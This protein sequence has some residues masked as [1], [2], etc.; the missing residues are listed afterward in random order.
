MSR[1]GDALLKAHEAFSR[2]DLLACE[3][4]CRAIL[5]SEPEQAE[6]LLL[7][8]ASLGRQGRAAEALGP[9]ERASQL[10]PENADAHYSLGMALTE[11]R[12]W[13]EAESAFLR[14]LQHAPQHAYAYNNLGVALRQVGG[15]A[16]AIACFREALAID[17]S[18]RDAQANLARSLLEAERYKE[19]LPHFEAL[20]ELGK[21]Q[22]AFALL[23]AEVLRK[24]GRCRAAVQMLREV[25]RQVPGQVNVIWQL[26]QAERDAGLFEDAV[27]TWAGVPIS[28]PERSRFE[29]AAGAAL[30]EL[31]RFA[32]SAAAYRRALAKDP[33]NVGA[34]LGLTSIKSF[35]PEERDI[36]AIDRVAQS[37]NLKK[38]D[39]AQILFALAGALE[40]KED[41]DRAFPNFQ[42]ANG[43]MRQLKGSELH[44]VIAR[45]DALR[46]R[47]QTIAAP[48]NAY[49]HPAGTPRP[50]FIVG[51]PRS[52]TT[53]VE[54]ILA[55]HPE[56]RGTGELT[57][58]YCAILAGVPLYP[59]GLEHLDGKGLK[60][61]SKHYLMGLADLAEGARYATDKLPVNYE[62]V[63]LIAEAFPEA[64]I[65]H[66]RREPLDV[67][68]S[69]YTTIFFEGQSFSYDLEELGRYYRLYRDMMTHWK[70]VVP[71]DRLIELVYEDLVADPE[72]QIRRLLEHCGLPWSDACLRFHENERPVQ[73]ASAT[74]VRQ[75]L[76]SSSVGR[77]RRYEK[78]LQP[79][80]DLLSAP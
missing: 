72:P 16:L 61:I 48:T 74:Q 6:A 15:L 34:W 14:A 8:G 53:L 5:R 55:S 45:H 24:T 60:A 21:R 12:R 35:S 37:P 23:H 27:R 47:F 77:W 49:E 42:S 13:K 73:T 70:A 43:I 38:Y 51:M 68:V 3:A 20:R 64:P 7:L 67:C 36:A 4:T 40:R 79:L 17:Q 69:C 50:I 58:L 28:G 54:Q 62:R 39:R 63:G 56:V 66:L 46:K 25:N 75:P 33:N 71:A 2:G 11:L 26:G 78:H 1:S 19:A 18:F 52:G 65:I 80:I 41:Y 59:D 44:T 22:P 29:S 57:L 76:Y 9:L 32:D 10:V 30:M 31:G